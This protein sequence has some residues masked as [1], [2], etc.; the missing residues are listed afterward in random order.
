MRYTKRVIATDM[1]KCYAIG[2]FNGT[3]GPS[4][5][6]ATEKDGPVRRFTLSGSVMETVAEGPGG[7]M[8]VMQT[9]GRDD[10]LLATCKFFSPNFGADDAKLVSYTR[11]TN[12]LWDCTTLCDLSYVHRFGVLKGADGTNWLL[13]CTIKSSCRKVKNDWLNPG[14]IYAAP[15]E[16]TLESYDGHH[17]L[18]LTLVANCQLQ[19]HG[20]YL[21]PDRSYA[22]ISTA[23]GVFR[24]LP[25]ATK[26]TNTWQVD[27][28]IVQPTSD[29]CV[30][31]LDGDGIGE[32]VTISPF[33]GDV[34]SVWHATKTPDV[35]TKV[36]TDSQTHSFLHAIWGGVLEGEHCAVIGN[37]RDDC[38]LM[39]L[40]FAD[41]DYHIETIDHGYGPANCWVFENGGH[42][43]IIAA[44]RETD[45]VA[46][47]DCS[48]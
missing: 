29:M 13:A 23:A 45:E 6:V 8:T 35:Y 15:L 14:A 19:N 43:H 34:L 42:S 36:W 38:N 27:C 18:P 22:L 24:Y 30:V 10:Q 40:Y 48:Q 37:R 47:Y 44:N 16:G 9:P 1:P 33:H 39:R 32:I 46:I 11:H 41:G 17:Q 25:P 2:M 7:V 21:A 31:D 5:V 28:L 3:D 4:F 12:G 20:F 26:D